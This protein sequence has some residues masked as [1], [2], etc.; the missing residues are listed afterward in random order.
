MQLHEMLRFHR[1][2]RGL[3][4]EQLAGKL[5]V[6]RQAV[7]KWERNETYPELDNLIRLSD[8]YDISLDELIRGA[9][10]LKKPFVIGDQ[11]F[12]KQFWAYL[13]YS[14]FFAALAGLGLKL[15]WPL[16]VLSGT[17]MASMLVSLKKGMLMLERKQLM[18]IRYDDYLS[19][20]RSVFN[21]EQC[22]RSVDYHE[23]ESFKLSYTKRLRLSP[24]DFAPDEFVV[25]FNLKDETVY[26]QEVTSHLLE[27]LPIVAD[28]LEKKGIRIE[29]EQA[30]IAK[31]IQAKDGP[32]RLALIRQ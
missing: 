19:K 20:L 27:H 30:L 14:L 7:S 21:Q 31:L 18:I 26:R 5:Y 11:T 2:K 16:I 1:E 12:N 17:V 25:Q 6:S 15:S 3:S 4:Q 28:F 24:Y 10:F 32:D 8:L 23:V 29:D 22:T 9:R 13:L